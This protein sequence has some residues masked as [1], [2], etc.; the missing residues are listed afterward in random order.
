MTQQ[1]LQQLA[2]DATDVTDGRNSSAK[3]SEPEH[4]ES[5]RMALLA[6]CAASRQMP[7]AVRLQQACACVCR[8]QQPC[9][10]QHSQHE[11]VLLLLLLLLLVRLASQTACSML[12]LG[13]RSRNRWSFGR[14]ALRAWCG[15]LIDRG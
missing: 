10:W 13:L 6:A 8:A 4:G 12:C 5:Q 15:H 3:G 1:W 14:R 11:A 2:T 7:G 9:M